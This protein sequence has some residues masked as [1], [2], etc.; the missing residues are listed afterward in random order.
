MPSG[1]L[2]P[3]FPFSAVRGMDD[4]KRALECVAID[5]DL[6]GLLIKGPTGTAKSLLV[7]SFVRMLPEMEI[8][9]VPQNVTDEQLF[10]GMDIENAIKNGKA[11][12]KDG[13]MQRA[14]GNIL[15]ID[16]IN[17]FDQK[18]LSSILECV[19][20]G[21]ILVE[22]EGIS[23]EYDC[24]TTV[25]A[26]MDPAEQ[27]LPDSITDRFDICVQ[28]Y[29]SRKKHDR[30]GIVEMNLE[31]DSDPE[32]FIEKYRGEDEELI[33]NMASAAE[34]LKDIDITGSDISKISQICINL[35]INGHRGDI[36][37]AKVS[38]TL[39]ALGGRDS[40][41]DEDIRDAAV[42]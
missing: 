2:N 32:A 5:R 42:M 16:N 1:V 17:L 25:I 3:L 35:D 9:N 40:I 14:D 30:C 12:I 28:T 34:R 37:V 8:I 27:I 19:E 20:S 21:K 39:S 10:G 36:S 33:R 38:R 23:A 7:R 4:V 13:L 26:T 24:N 41:S 11:Q 29:S 6:T 31:F 18:M 15:Y 22:R